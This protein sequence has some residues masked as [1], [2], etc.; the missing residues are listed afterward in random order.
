MAIIDRFLTDKLSLSVAEKFRFYKRVFVALD[1]MCV[2]VHLIYTVAFAWTKILPLIIFNAAS[3][4]FY[5]GL[6]FFIKK[7]K[8]AAAGTGLAIEIMLHVAL[9]T[10]LI[11]WEYGFAL[12][13]FVIMATA[14]FLPYKK[15]S[16]CYILSGTAILLFFMLL[17][18]STLAEPIYSGERLESISKELYV[19]NCLVAIVPLFLESYMYRLTSEK[20]EDLLFARNKDLIV[21]ASIDPLTS[22]L[23]RRS[24]E[25]KLDEAYNKR[26]LMSEPFCVVIGDIDDFKL[27]NDTYGHDCGDYVLKTISDMLSSSLRSR[28]NI[29]RWGGE[30][31]LILLNST[32]I[33]CTIQTVERIRRNVAEHEFE[34]EGQKFHVTMTFGLSWRRAFIEEMLKDADDHLYA[35]KAN[36]KNQIVYDKPPETK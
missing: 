10:I 26:E 19:F 11:G 36:G 3:M 34:Y 22:L 30:E 18:A 25:Q 13:L 7:G 33:G 6:F 12:Q 14:F 9:E 1:V 20:A 29:A 2:I 23:N 16:A 35:G 24:M 31:I 4:L 28:D 5:T 15:N 32:D 27:V 21:L 17:T 8:Y